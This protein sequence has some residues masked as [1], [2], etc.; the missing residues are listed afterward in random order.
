MGRIQSFLLRPFKD[1]SDTQLRVLYS[2]MAL[3]SLAWIIYTASIYTHL[4]PRHSDECYWTAEKRDG[5]EVVVVS[6]IETGGAADRAGVHVGDRVVSI[7]GRTFD[8]TTDGSTAVNNAQLV[9][10][11]TPINEAVP[12]V[13]EREGRLIELS[14]VLVDEGLSTANYILLTFSAF[15]FL[16]L[17]IGTMVALAQPR[18]MVQ[19]RFFLTAV[20]AVFGFT[21]PGAAS[22]SGSSVRLVSNISLVITV[23]Q[24]FFGL[25]FYP[26]WLL[27]CSTFPVDQDRFTTR[28]R[29]FFL[30]LPV[31]LYIL[32]LL[33]AG[34]IWL[35]GAPAQTA[36]NLILVGML[37]CGTSSLWYFFRGIYFLYQ[38]YRKMP[39]TIDRRPMRVIL[40]GTVIAAMA[41]IFL[42]L[43]ASVPV[44]REIGPG[45]AYLVLLILALPISFGY[46]IFKY[47]VMDFRLVVKTTLV[48]ALTMALI[49]GLYVGVGYTISQALGSIIN[50]RLEGT[51]EVAVFI[52]FLL[53]MDPVKQRLQSAIE[54][55][56][57]PQRRDYSTY[58]ASYSERLTE[59][60]STEAVASLIAD[61]LSRALDLDDVRILH[62]IDDKSTAGRPDT[63]FDAATLDALRPLLAE[64]HGLIWLER[65]DE[66]HLVALRGAYPY[67]IGL[68]A[69][70]ETIGAVLLGHPRGGER[71]S[72]RQM[73]FISSVVTQG[74]AAFESV[75]LLEQELSRRRYQEELATARRI[76]QSLLPSTLPKLPRISI[77][78][79][80]R[81][82]QA[83]GGDYFNVVRLDSS[84]MMVI[85]ADVSGKGLPA[86]LYMAELHGMVCIASTTC[87]T[88]DE[89][90]ATLN[91]HL[92]REMPRG[93]FVTA[94]VMLLDTE[95]KTA[96]IA[97]AGHTP[98]I[99]L[100]GCN[101]DAR[102][103]TLAPAGMALG[104]APNTI[105]ASTLEQISFE[106][107]PGETF[108]LYSDGVS[109]A[110]NERRDEFSDRRLL[111]VISGAGSASVDTLCSDILRNVETFRDGAE[112]NDD[113]TIVV[114]RIDGEME[115]HP[116]LASSDA[117]VSAM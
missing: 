17:L 53:L 27:F 20:T 61:T 86:S 6:S 84:R 69:R 52:L 70:G 101:G 108:I 116:A 23:L 22:F 102:I 99:R 92:C 29:K 63:R 37:I 32:V 88:A 15:T 59:L 107:D 75:R 21:F 77:S 46:A 95:T 78:A 34:V 106:Y 117:E 18:G 54:D 11:I 30:Y 40:I 9:L 111:D 35:F 58:L 100:G 50:K 90:L 98:I 71:I 104:M 33:S 113:I 13:V 28:K 8:D 89:I 41:L 76:Q 51:I 68:Y 60:V 43:M 87:N 91:E 72:G 62:P 103:E 3:V 24:G 38:G 56:F 47:Q 44:V 81:P 45:I 19:R 112:Q 79:L 73:P 93:T 4:N 48:Y 16:W 97:R 49:A 7:N 55:R 5:K 82:A 105:F 39:S 115:H 2:L 114:V 67:V 36:F 66:P 96:S 65:L 10:N 74:A 42:M 26:L 80:S 83:V 64:S 31:I 57:F 110:M 85:V 14:I 1:L 109:E 25:M 94:T 12:Y